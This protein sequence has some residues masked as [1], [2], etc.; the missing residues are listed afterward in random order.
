M[1]SRVGW[2]AMAARPF[3][4]RY[5]RAVLGRIGRGGIAVACALAVLAAAA[6][7][8]AGGSFSIAVIP[9]TQNMVDYKHQQANGFPMDASELFLAEMKWIADRATSRGGDVVFAAAVG[10]V[11]QH[12]SLVID[13]MH[14]KRGFRPIENP[15][16]ATEL[17]VTPRTTSEMTLANKG[18]GLLLAADLPFGVAPGNH[19]Y[20]SMWS[21]A[22]YPPVSDQSKIDM[23]P[24]TLGMLHVGGLNNFRNVF[25][26]KRRFF[27][28]KPWYVANDGGGINSAQTF[29]A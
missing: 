12:Q 19:D 1:S 4:Q 13:R 5:P 28:G 25:G 11:W 6:A 27:A 15:W 20:D 17:E 8:A 9:D 14:S 10:D 18:Y 7:H 29:S 24:K 2:L 23:T 3:Y 21:D 26:A 16:F 22:R